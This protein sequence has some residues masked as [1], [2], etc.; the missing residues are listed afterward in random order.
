LNED[1][2]LKIKALVL[3]SSCYLLKSDLHRVIY[4][5]HKILDIESDLLYNN[6]GKLTD[7]NLLQ[8]NDEIINL[9]LR[10]A[11]RQNLFTAHYRLGKLRLCCYY[12]KE[13]TDII[14][15]QLNLNANEIN[16][17]NL[18]ELF[19]YIQVNSRIKINF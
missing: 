6:S 7:L 2:K 4:F 1:H 9:E 12:L 19:D 13:M 10:I 16:R 11:I 5:Y 3:I 8:F 15:N 18:L 14:D 17:T